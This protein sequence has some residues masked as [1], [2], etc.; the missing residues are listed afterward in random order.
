L[1]IGSPCTLNE[2]F[3]RIGIPVIFLNSETI[4]KKIESSS[5]HGIVVAE[6][7]GIPVKW[8]APGQD[9]IGGEH[10]FQ[11]YFLGTGRKKQKPGLIPP[12]KNLKE[13]QDRLINAI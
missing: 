4:L 6:A 1:I 10:K 9:I 8:I 11:D 13:I 12:I 2:V 3:K 5:L 7:F